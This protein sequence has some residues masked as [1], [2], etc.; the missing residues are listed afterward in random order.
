M[1]S[2]DSNKRIT[3]QLM[4]DTEENLDIKG[5]SLIF[6]NCC[7]KLKFKKIAA[8]QQESGGDY[9]NSKKQFA[10]SFFLLKNV[11]VDFRNPL[12]FRRLSAKP[13]RPKRLRGL[14]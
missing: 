3:M 10:Y 4:S 8:N 6:R 7:R 14:G 11:P 13:P 1:Q 9:T 2:K 5:I 12:P